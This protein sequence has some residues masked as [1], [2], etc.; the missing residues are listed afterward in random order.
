MN[1]ILKL[2]FT[3]V[4]VTVI[5]TSNVSANQMLEK[6]WDTNIDFLKV[7]D[8]IMDYS[9]EVARSVQKI[10]EVGPRRFIFIVP[11]AE[12][13]AWKIFWGRAT[14]Y[15]TVQIRHF[16]SHQQ[17]ITEERIAYI[18]A[19]NDC[20][21]TMEIN[22]VVL[23]KYNSSQTHEDVYLPDPQYFF[24]E[25]DYYIGRKSDDDYLLSGDNATAS[26]VAIYECENAAN[27]SARSL[28]VNLE[29]D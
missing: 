28:E 15:D 6:R 24:T 14:L 10:K 11:E 25:D 13:G 12:G 19:S 4:F 27:G 17:V 3:F 2:F 29:L 22:D 8:N 23:V 20:D 9:E 1:K 21:G 18:G 26:F 16:G 7:N 5:F